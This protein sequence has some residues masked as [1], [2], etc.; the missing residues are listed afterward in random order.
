MVG[1]SDFFW[2]D[3]KH[4][5]SSTQLRYS[6]KVSSLLCCLLISCSF[7]KICLIWL[8]SRDAYFFVYLFYFIYFAYLFCCLLFSHVT[9]SAFM[10]PLLFFIKFAFQLL[11]SILGVS[12]TLPCPKNIAPPIIIMLRKY[13]IPPEI[14]AIFYTINV[15]GSNW[16]H[17]HV[18][19]LQWR[20]SICATGTDVWNT[21]HRHV[22]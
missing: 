21:N 11:L 22:R 14:L 19:I 8:W 1:I 13:H 17:I 4:P 6:P 12:K 20:G 2:R 9:L 5:F 7:E 18:Q 10:L 16:T 3:F 15:L